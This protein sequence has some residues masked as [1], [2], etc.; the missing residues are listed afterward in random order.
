MPPLPEN[1]FV[2]RPL[3]RTEVEHISDMRLKLAEKWRSAESEHDR[4]ERMKKGLSSRTVTLDLLRR[5]GIPIRPNDA[6]RF[7]ARR[8]EMTGKELM[9][10]GEAGKTAELFFLEGVDESGSD[11]RGEP[12]LGPQVVAFRPFEMDDVLR[13]SDALLF[14][15]D[16]DDP[17]TAF[18]LSVDVKTAPEKAD[19]K[20]A[21]NLFYLIQQQGAAS[22]Y[23]ADPSAEHP[24]ERF[25][26]PSEGMVP[27]LQIAVHLPEEAVSYLSANAT[28]PAEIRRTMDTL[29][30]YVHD[31]VDFQLKVYLGVLSRK[32][33]S[34]DVRNGIVRPGFDLRRFRIRIEDAPPSDLPSGL[35]A[36]YRTAQGVLTKLAFDAEERSAAA[37]EE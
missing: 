2:R 16:V 35:Q 1:P 32:I 12:W 18:T 22:V 7:Q 25:S 17:T 5:R 29:G 15:R 4:I 33:R 11:I 3:P 20:A 30:A 8:R 36:A 13:G 14:V 6:E 28:R 9:V 27:A 23:W 21:D 24:E 31:Q 34:Q 19:Q 10:K 26:L 37:E